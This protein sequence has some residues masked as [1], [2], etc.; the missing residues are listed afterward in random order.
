[1]YISFLRGIN[2]SGKKKI[3][4]KTLKILYETL[5]FKEVKTCLNTGN[6][7]F[8]TLLSKVD[9]GTKIEE[10]IQSKFD[11]NIEVI[12]RSKEELKLLIEAYPFGHEGK[13]R[14]IT[15]L[16]TSCEMIDKERVSTV[17]KT[18]DKIEFGS[19]NSDINGS[20]NILRKYAKDKNI[21]RLIT[22]VR[23]KGF[24]ENPIRL[25]VI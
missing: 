16:K 19:I 10:A 7:I 12:I 23:D 22:E 9:I 8:C 5:G 24:R 6:I 11:L 18:S 1:M 25:S 15:L 21:P 20:L 4:M 3:E 17:S 13:N 2:V 14:Y